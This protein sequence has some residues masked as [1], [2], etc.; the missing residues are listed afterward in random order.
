M[1]RR[2]FAALASVVADFNGLMSDRVRWQ[3]ADAIA[4]ICRSENSRFDRGR[5]F[6]ACSLD[7][8]RRDGSGGG[9]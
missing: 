1:S 4:V 6:G 8:N 2:Q 3:L 9:A 7:E 5:F